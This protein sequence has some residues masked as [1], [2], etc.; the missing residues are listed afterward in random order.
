[1]FQETGLES[2]EQA[3]RKGGSAYDL[4]VKEIRK[5]E[6]RARGLGYKDLA[7]RIARDPEYGDDHGHLLEGPE[8]TIEFN[9]AHDRKNWT[10]SSGRTKPTTDKRK[11]DVGK[12]IKTGWRKSSE[13]K[14]NVAA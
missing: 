12:W 2:R 11:A 4:A 6:K 8:A 5:A 7:D 3:K 1:M 14:Y 10:D 9:R 13:W